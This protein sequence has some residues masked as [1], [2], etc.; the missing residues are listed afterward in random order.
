MSSIDIYSEL[1]C[2]LTNDHIVKEPISLVCGH[3][4]CKDCITDQLIIDCKMCGEKTPSAVLNIKMESKP[5]KK[6]IKSSIAGL[7]DDLEK[8]SA[9]GIN[10]F[11]SY[12]IFY[13]VLN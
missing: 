11:K 3:C 6:L 5:I 4:I 2:G 12:N 7:F 8:R 13:L 9:A 10:T 1:S